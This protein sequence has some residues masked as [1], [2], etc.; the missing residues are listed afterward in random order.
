MLISLSQEQ[1]QAIRLLSLGTFL[2]YFD[3][4][5]YVHMTVV[6]NELFFPPADSCT[7]SLLATLAFVSTF[8]FRPLGALLLGYIGDTYGRGITVMISTFMMAVTCLVMVYIPTYAR[9]GIT[10]TWIV[11]LCRVLQGIASMSE[12]VGAQL[13]LTETIQLPARYPAV[14]LMNVFG[15]LGSIAALGVATL[16]TTQAFNWRMAFMLGACVAVIG[17]MA[18]TALRESPEFADAKR[19]IRGV[20][21]E[22]NKDTK[23]LKS[24]LFY[25]EKVNKQTAL[26]YFLIKCTSPFFIYFTYIYCGEILQVTFGYDV[27][28]TL[29]HNFFI[30]VVQLLGWSVLRTYLSTKLYPLSILQFV[31]KG[32]FAFSLCLPWLLSMI[33]APWQLFLIQSFINVFMANDLPAVPIFFRHFPVFKRFSYTSFLYASAYALVYAVTAFG[34]THLVAYLGYWGLWVIML[35]IFMGYGYG[36]NHF[37]KLDVESDRYKQETAIQARASSAS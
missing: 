9:I 19:R 20:F 35:P 13:Y 14:G 23:S 1:K 28:Q 34:L 12:I 37:K 7:K 16:V 33:S 26:A 8:V 22:L 32:L 3:L 15:D 5:L 17:V 4:F 24:S 25:H 11:V 31:W 27:H 30:S 10:A 18:R 36:I 29:L 6:L 21:K 2:E